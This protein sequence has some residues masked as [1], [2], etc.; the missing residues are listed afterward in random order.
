[1]R[2]GDTII[3]F[4]DSEGETFTAGAPPAPAMSAPSPPLWIFLLLGSAVFL[5]LKGHS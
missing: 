5:V 2:Y 1:M 3:D 4:P